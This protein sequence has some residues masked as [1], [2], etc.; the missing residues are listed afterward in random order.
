MGMKMEEKTT[1]EELIDS[2]VEFIGDLI[3]KFASTGEL[4]PCSTSD[5]CTVALA[6]D[7]FDLLPDAC[8]TPEKAWDSIDLIQRVLVR[9]HNPDIDPAKFA[10]GR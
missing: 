8:P 1:T 5:A 7:R 2:S 6:Y 4:A 10:S 9:Q 3:K